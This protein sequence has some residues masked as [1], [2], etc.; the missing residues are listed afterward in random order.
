MVHFGFLMTRDRAF[1]ATSSSAKQEFHRM[2]KEGTPNLQ[3]V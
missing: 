3:W 1:G 2:P